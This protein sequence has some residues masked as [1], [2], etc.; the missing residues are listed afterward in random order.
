MRNKTLIL[1]VAPS[2]YFLP[3]LVAALRRHHNQG[4]IFLLNLLLGWTFLGWVGALVW[5]ATKVNRPEVEFVDSRSSRARRTEFYAGLIV[6]AI[7]VAIG[8]A[9]AIAIP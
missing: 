7:V 2:T 8:G 4:A 9:I 3:W 6:V 5:S 1:L